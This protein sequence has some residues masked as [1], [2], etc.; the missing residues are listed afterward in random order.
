MRKL[1]RKNKRKAK[2][3]LKWKISL[4]LESRILRRKM[5]KVSWMVKRKRKNKID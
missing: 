3:I 1:K 2:T 4:A 5:T